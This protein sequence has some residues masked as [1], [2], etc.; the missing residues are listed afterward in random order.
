MATT[1]RTER[2]VIVRDG[3]RLAVRDQGPRDAES[4]IVLLHG[5]CLE[6]GSWAGQIRHLTRQWGDRIRIISYDHRGHGRS[7]SAPNRT[8]TVEQLAE[9]LADVLTALRVIGPW[10][11]TDW[12]SR[13]RLPADSLSAALPASWRVPRRTCCAGSP[14][15]RLSVPF[16]CLPSL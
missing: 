7:G 12:S 4:T 10:S 5:L 2:T 8:Y 9:D 3:V 15:S 16:G 1:G 11:R 13:R 6:K 14:P